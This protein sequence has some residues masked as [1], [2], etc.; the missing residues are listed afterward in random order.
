MLPDLFESPG[1]EAPT[2]RDDPKTSHAAAAVITPHMTEVQ[3]LVQRFALGKPEGFTDWELVEAFPDLGPSTLRTR[4]AEL[5]ECNIILDSMRTARP[6]GGQPHTV[7][8]HRGFVE[9]APDVIKPSRPVT[10]DDKA[11]A[12][13]LAN[14]LQQAGEYWKGQGMVCADKVI[15]GAAMLR[16]LAK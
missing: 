4:R 10:R 12:L 15:E 11:A 2:R 1:G 7:W 6:D 5:V 13:V 16:R 8:I 3:K 14:E 9:D